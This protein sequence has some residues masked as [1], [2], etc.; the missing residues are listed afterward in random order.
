MLAITNKIKTALTNF[1][2]VEIII[3][4]T[5]PPINL[6]VSCEVRSQV[7]IKGN[8]QYYSLFVINKKKVKL[9][10]N[11]VCVSQLFSSWTSFGW[12]WSEK[13]VTHLDWF[14]RNFLSGGLLTPFFSTISHSFLL[15]LNLI[16]SCFK[17]R[18][19]CYVVSFPI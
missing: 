11:K 17:I 6:S 10:N 1:N 18:G 14:F 8:V 12:E 13:E 9:R 19:L 7:V 3:Q 15:T 5:Q 16:W 2:M 4:P